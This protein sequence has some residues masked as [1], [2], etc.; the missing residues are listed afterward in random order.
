MK[1]QLAEEI[2]LSEAEPLS[3]QVTYLSE[4]EVHFSSQFSFAASSFAE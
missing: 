3:D 2:F 4:Q 1:E